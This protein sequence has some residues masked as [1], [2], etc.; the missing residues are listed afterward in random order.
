MMVVG[1]KVESRLS[2]RHGSIMSNDSPGFVSVLWDSPVDVRPLSPD[3][4]VSVMME[5][6]LIALTE[7]P[8]G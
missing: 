3:A 5:R 2:G 1:T 8:A 7:E 6:D 4:D